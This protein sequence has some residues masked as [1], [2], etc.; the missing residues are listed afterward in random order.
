MIAWASGWIRNVR[1]SSY[2]AS[3]FM[4]FSGVTWS[5]CRSRSSDEAPVVSRESIALPSG[6]STESLTGGRSSTTGGA[7][8]SIVMSSTRNGAVV[9]SG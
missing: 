4:W 7:C 5:K 6:K 2:Q 9:P 3:G 1:A 8:D